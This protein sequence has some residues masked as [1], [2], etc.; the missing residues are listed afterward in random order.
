MNYRPQRDRCTVSLPQETDLPA[1]Q[2]MRH[3]HHHELGLFPNGFL[4]IMTPPNFLLFLFKITC[5]SLICGT[6]L[7]LLFSLLVPNCNS[8]LFLKKIHFFSGK[9]SV[10]FLR[11]TL[12][13]GPFRD[14]EKTRPGH[15]WGWWASMGSAHRALWTRCFLADPGIWQ[16]FFWIWSS[17]VLCWKLSRVYSGCIVRHPPLLIK[18]LVLSISTQLALPCDSWN[19]AVHLE[20]C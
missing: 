9:I 17:A 4:F 6:C 13:D 20:L 8:L 18:S 16:S 10:F 1:T 11:S 3:H 19:Q 14:P 7:W 12:L 5:L 2:P 15:L